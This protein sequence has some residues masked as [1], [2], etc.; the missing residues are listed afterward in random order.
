[1]TE[2]RFELRVLPAGIGDALVLDYGRGVDRHRV[3]ID[4][5]VTTTADAVGAVLT[6]QPI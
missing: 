3:V 1:M 2:E 6:E 5:G 4:G